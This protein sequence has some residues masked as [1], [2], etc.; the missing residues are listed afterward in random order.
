MTP[1]DILRIARAIGHE[2]VVY[3]DPLND[4]ADAFAVQ[5]FLLENGCHIHPHRITRDGYIEP[6]A[7]YDGTK[8]GLRRAIVEAAKGVVA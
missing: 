3:F 1:S 4:S 2:D 7:K 5:M 8:A 6:L